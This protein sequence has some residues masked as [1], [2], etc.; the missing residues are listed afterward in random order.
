MESPAP[1]LDG[2]E[3]DNEEDGDNTEG[4]ELGEESGLLQTDQGQEKEDQVEG[5]SDHFIPILGKQSRRT[6]GGRRS[7]DICWIRIPSFCQTKVP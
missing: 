5:Y 7:C 4:T 2:D 6:D 1:D 3:D